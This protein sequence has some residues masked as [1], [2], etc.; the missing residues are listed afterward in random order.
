M[1][2]F[3]FLLLPILLLA[4]APAEAACSGATPAISVTTA[5]QKLQ[6]DQALSIADLNRRAGV[7]DRNTYA[8]GLTESEVSATTRYEM[9]VS[10]EADGLFCV[11]FRSITVEL[12]LAMKVHVAAELKP[13]SCLYNAALQHEQ[14][15]VIVERKMLPRAKARVAVVL[16]GVAARTETA[17]DAGIAQRNL[18][19]AADAAIQEAMREIAAQKKRQQSALDT[20]DEYRR[21]S[22]ACGSAALRAVV[23]GP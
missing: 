21:V 5:E 2:A 18:R 3:P 10:P 23:G 12:Q 17:G 20:P 9:L 4:G 14:G 19:A 15:H 1:R 16:A 13:G 6:Q 22:R 7:T 11:S 8:L